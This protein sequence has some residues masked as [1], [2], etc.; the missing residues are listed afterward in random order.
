MPGRPS[1]QLARLLGVRIGASPSW[2]L[3]LFLM[4]YLLSG[5][6]A[7]DLGIDQTQ[8]FFVA[9]GAAFCFFASLVAH[10]LGHAVA[11]RRYGIGVLGID[12]WFFGGIAKLSR[13]PSRPREELVVAA[14]GPAVTALVIA[15]AV[16]AGILSSDSASAFRDAALLDGSDPSVVQA[17]LGWL[18]FVNAFLL[19]FNLVPAFPLDG[20]RIARGIAW[21]LTGSRHRATRIS[22]S[23]GQAFGLLL[24]AVGVLIAVAVD[25]LNGL[26]LAV[27]GWFLF[28]GARGALVASAF[29]ERLEGVTAGD[30]MDD[31]PVTLQATTSALDARETV[32]LRYREPWAP[33]VDAGGRLMGIV[34]GTRVDGAVE[35]GRPALAVGELL[36]D[37]GTDWRVA[38]ET[39]LESL[40]VHEPLRRLGALAVVDGE[41]RLLGVLTVDR[42]RRALAASAAGP[43]S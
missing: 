40:I 5:S 1:I 32:F 29:A 11:A 33:V 2:F 23:I 8:A 15:L 39:P 6:F 13:E 21:G 24:G 16:G 19:V 4:V 9:V 12:L 27:L 17:L 30:L 3:V 42:V 7:D 28:Q 25:P 10:E 26:W 14:A 18:A 31:D 22:A 37:D 35:A 36:D 34:S 38:R 43:R 41:Q 20:G